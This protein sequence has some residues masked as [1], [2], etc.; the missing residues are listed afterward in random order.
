MEPLN[1]VYLIVKNNEP[2]F[3]TSHRPLD[4]QLNKICGTTNFYVVELSLIDDDDHRSVLL[5]TDYNIYQEP[6]FLN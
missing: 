2:F 3:A 4:S 5:R 1:V 6:Q